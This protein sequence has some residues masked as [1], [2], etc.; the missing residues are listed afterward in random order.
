MDL[1]LKSADGSGEERLVLKSEADKRPT[2]WSKDGRFLLYMSVDPKT[3]DDIWVLPDPSGS[4]ENAKPV[5]YLRTEFQEGLGCIFSRWALDR[6]FVWGVRCAGSVR[7][8]ILPG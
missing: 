6:V 8:A 5:P 7:P 4:A 2:S 1:Y 3:R